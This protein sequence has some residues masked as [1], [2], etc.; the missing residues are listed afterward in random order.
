MICAVRQN[1]TGRTA[2][3]TADGFLVPGSLKANSV[4]YL[5]I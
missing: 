5:N 3:P 1:G 4:S 2:Q